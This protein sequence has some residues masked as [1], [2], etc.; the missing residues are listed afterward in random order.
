MHFSSK[1]THDSRAQMARIHGVRGMDWE[2]CEGR[3]GEERGCGWAVMTWKD[4]RMGEGMDI[5]AS[6]LLQIKICT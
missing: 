4:K 3:H 6:I 2:R 5:W 1:G